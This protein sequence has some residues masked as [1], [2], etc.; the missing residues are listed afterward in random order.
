MELP[1][2][3]RIPRVP[4]V[5]QFTREGLIFVLLSLAIGAAAV[6]TGNNIL[7]L[8]FSLM[9]GLIVVSGMLS[10][11]TLSRVRAN[12]EFPPNLFAGV[13]SNCYVTV[14]NQK[15]RIPSLAIRFLAGGEDFP[16]ISRYFFYLSPGS[17]VRGFA[18]VTFPARGMFHFR[19]YE[20]QTRFPFSF[21]VKIRRFSTDQTVRV[22]PRI[23][24][25]ADEWLSRLTEGVL[26]ESP[27]RGD[28]RQLLHLREYGPGDS[29]KKIHW[30]ASARAER[31][32]V[33][34][35]QKEQGRDVYVYFDCYPQ[36]REMKDLLDR[37]AS[38]TAS[39]AFLIRRR[40]L[41]ATFV[42]ADRH[43]RLSG[44]RTQLQPLLDFLAEIE[45]GLPPF[46]QPPIT[47]EP[48]AVVLVIRSKRVGS[49]APDL[50]QG[51]MVNVED[52]LDQSQPVDAPILEST[53]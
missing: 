32:L 19:Q 33:K 31:L 52:S 8:I 37:A 36:R 40:G 49:V 21:F 45:T 1:L 16:Q 51:A 4:I 25:L 9:L 3:I 43:F 30:K 17:E 14:S 34:E 41:D 26:V 29:S 22:Y 47:P 27:Y 6:N 35:F 23:F 50:P 15:K 18:A 7:Y 13:R 5:I 39:L 42:F 2:R 20:L 12:V 46:F 38:L 53:S 28:S 44:S 11:R 10:R 48:N 24:H